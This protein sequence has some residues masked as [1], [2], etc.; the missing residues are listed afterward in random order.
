MNTSPD[1]FCQIPCSDRSDIEG[2]GWRASIVNFD[3]KAPIE[4][5]L[6]STRYLMYCAP[7]LR[8]SSGPHW[9]PDSKLGYQK[10]PA[11]FLV[12]A[13]FVLPIK[14][15]AGRYCG[16]V[17]EFE[18]DILNSIIEPSMSKA[19]GTSVVVAGL[20]ITTH[21][22]VHLALRELTVPGDTPSESIDDLSRCLLV[23][24]ARMLSHPARGGIAIDPSD[25]VDEA[26]AQIKK[27]IRQRRPALGNIV[28]LTAMSERHLQR[29]F[30]DE[31]G[32]SLQ[33]YVAAYRI[34]LA[35]ELLRD[36]DLALKQIAYDLG[37]ANPSHFSRSFKSATGI[38]PSA[39]QRAIRRDLSH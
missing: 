20:N 12:P 30:K 37:Y 10:C 2:K 6:N 9:R 19:L 1:L 22:L 8:P 33:D 32:M 18:P 23:C 27:N 39:F 31:M 34:K 16:F 26:A 24:A 35:K 3:V 29:R 13:N 4:T 36:S 21:Q 7:D 28:E 25:A 15:A 14:F 5:S 11:Y 38:S 17:Y